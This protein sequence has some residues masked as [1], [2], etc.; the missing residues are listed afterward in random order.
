MVVQRLEWPPGTLFV[1]PPP[2][3][4]PPGPRHREAA[5]SFFVRLV[6]YF[7]Y[8]SSYRFPTQPPPPKQVRQASLLSELRPDQAGSHHTPAVPAAEPFG[9]RDC[10]DLNM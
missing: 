5:L 3:Q 8:G 6:E 7:L 1:R 10:R 4:K 9:H 2:A